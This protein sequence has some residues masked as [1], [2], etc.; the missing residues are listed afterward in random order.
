MKILKNDDSWYEYNTLYES[1]IMKPAVNIKCIN[2]C[3]HD[4]IW[5]IIIQQRQ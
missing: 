4:I 2:F 5:K 1:I 3:L